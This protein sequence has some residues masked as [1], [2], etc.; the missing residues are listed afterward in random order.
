[1]KNIGKYIIVLGLIILT[2]CSE[3]FLDS[4]PLTTITDENFYRTK[5]DAELAIVGCYDGV[6]MLDGTTNSFTVI[7]EVLS[8]NTFGG[9][10]NNDGYGFQVWD[11]FNIQRSAGEV[12]LLNPNWQ[13]YYK[14]IYR[15]NV[16]L[17]KMEQIDWEDD[18]AYRN[19]IEAQARFLRA[20]CYF[21]MV[22]LWEKV[23]L[24]TEP[25]SGNIPQAEADEIYKVIAD[26]LM[27]AAENGTETVAAGRIN[28]WV[29]KAYLARVFLF[30]TGYYNKT[31]LVGKY[32]KTQ[33]LDGLEDVIESGN[34]ELVSDFKNLW[35]PASTKKNAAGTALESTYSGK[36]NSETVFAIKHN[37]TSN[38]S[39][40][41]DGNHWVVM[42]GLRQQAAN[43]SPYGKG[44]GACPVNA[45][46]YDAYEDGDT[47][48][49]ASI[50]GIEEEE[51]EFDKGDQREY[52]G[53]NI[54]KYTPIANPDGK[55]VSEANGGTSFMISQ[56][57]D[58]IIMRYSDVLL[59]A[60]ELGSANAQTYYDAIRSRAGLTSKTVSAANILAERRLEFAFEGIRYWDLLRQGLSV[61]AETIAAEI[62]VENGGVPTQKVILSSNVTKT[63]G[64]QQIPQQQITRSAGVL[65]Q[66]AGW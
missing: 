15:T 51:L 60:A 21:D 58:N 47:R 62:T 59:M 37:I 25:I 57:Q 46:L 8:D 31:D 22:R 50:I 3:S 11:E 28:K 48:R 20:Y 43:F 45:E 66:N 64:F 63:R 19:N 17:Q 12:D 39:G 24:L 40:T 32:T 42:I 41:T 36:D 26:D 1:M 2:S 61:A 55:D 6:Q 5:K 10:G 27:F 49:D 13:S 18:E 4:E 52:T 7:S 56:Y 33:A 54:K 23:P 35:L 34:F 65:K 14:A 16:L 29:A 30:Y 38:W 44:W 9:T 53:Y